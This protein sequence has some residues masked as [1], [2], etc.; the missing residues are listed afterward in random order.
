[1]KVITT[2]IALLVLIIL[3]SCFLDHQI[4]RNNSIEI[5]NF[6][7]QNYNL[8][9][10][11]EKAE[12]KLNEIELDIF[13][14]LEKLKTENPEIKETEKLKDQI[15]LYFKLRKDIQDFLKYR[16]LD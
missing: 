4:H 7:T 15:K 8:D 9:V 3:L 1:M 10:K 13:K 6:N 14:L 11:R 2:S 5:E 12:N 16:W